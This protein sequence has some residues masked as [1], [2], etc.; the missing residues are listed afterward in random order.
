M[1]FSDIYS[2]GIT[3]D[4]KI[5][6]AFIYFEWSSYKSYNRESLL[7]KIVRNLEKRKG[8]K[9]NIISEIE[10]DCNNFY[11]DHKSSRGYVL[12]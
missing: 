2:H 12:V 4:V 8:E 11:I 10:R 3:L 6:P 9:R 5:N 1:I 7:L